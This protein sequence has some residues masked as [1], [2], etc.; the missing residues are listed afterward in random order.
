MKHG[1][2]FIPISYCRGLGWEGRECPPPLT[3]FTDMPA[4]YKLG[5]KSD[6][7]A[8]L[9]LQTWKRERHKHYH[10][11]RKPMIVVFSFFHFPSSFSSSFLSPS[12]P[13]SLTPSFSLNL[14]E[15]KVDF[16]CPILSPLNSRLPHLCR[17]VLCAG[18]NGS[19]YTGSMSVPQLQQQHRQA[20]LPWSSLPGHILTLTLE[21]H[22]WR[23][24]TLSCKH[25][26]QGIKWCL[27]MR[28]YKAYGYFGSP[29]FTPSSYCKYF[30]GLEYVMWFQWD[31]LK[32][33][34]LAL[35][36]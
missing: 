13:L 18:D 8:L 32:S 5:R 22:S 6:C 30:T 35:L 21:N 36:R 11:N 29:V 10:S 25:K 20:V 3:M 24:Y 15:L 9:S 4:D 12:P 27:S 14:P 19:N 26:R 16:I 7:T 33:S 1:V 23:A 34:L 2:A 31:L 17:F 28:W